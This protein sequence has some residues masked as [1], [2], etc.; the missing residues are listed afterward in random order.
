VEAP[1]ALVYRV[2]RGMSPSDVERTRTAEVCLTP[3]VAAPAAQR[4]AGHLERTQLLPLDEAEAA[5]V[6]FSLERARVLRRSEHSA[7]IRRLRRALSIGICIWISTL[8]PDVWIT[9]W[10][11]VGHLPTFL[12]ARAIGVAVVL[13]ALWRLKRLPEPSVRTLWWLD[14]CVFTSASVLVSAMCVNMSGIASP[15]APGIIAILVARGATTL[16]PWRRGLWLFGIPALAYPTT[17]ALA[18]LLDPRVAAQ[19]HDPMALGS[20]VSLMYILAECWVMLTL[21]GHFAWRL[22]REALETRNIGRYKLERRLGSGGM[23]DVWAAFDVTLKQRVA[24][25]TVTGHRPGSLMLARLER[26]VRALAELT[27]PNTVRVFDYGV[28]DD[29]LWY[30]AM[31][32]LHGENLRE[33]V[34]RNGPMPPD[35]LLR[36]ARQVLR[37]LGEA[38]GKGIIHR[39]IK[40]ENVFVAELGGESDIAKLLDFGIAKATVSG[41]QTLTNTGFVAGTPAYMAPEL[42]QGHPA[43]V[44]SDIYSFGATLYYA[45]TAR[46]PFVEDDPVA[47]FAAHLHRTPERMSA[48]S[49]RPIHPALEGIVQRCMAKDPEDRYAS[50]QAL[51]EELDPSVAHGPGA[52]DAA[53]ASEALGRV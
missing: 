27:H 37:A 2:L 16:A 52:L 11:H 47:L 49:T 44:R 5:A 23:G 26:E 14:V 15:Y 36:I 28:T 21:G 31:E 9:V 45:L 6:S 25:K 46:L 1:G 43:D 32:L 17:V 50:T 40:P 38:H 3:G 24:L 12:V 8:V 13:A 51:L 4:E 18:A 39:D 35:R 29:G 53:L 48:V 7:S 41:E 10:L 34:V 33:H 19:F 30:Y 42:I 22:R 20:F